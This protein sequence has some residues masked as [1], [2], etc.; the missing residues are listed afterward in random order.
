ML[1]F[2]AL[3]YSAWRISRAAGATIYQEV[4]TI[5]RS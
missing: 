5:M 3:E 1:K 2:F 4:E